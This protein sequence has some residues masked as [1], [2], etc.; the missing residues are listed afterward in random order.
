MT[1]EELIKELKRLPAHA[2]VRV[3][4]ESSIWEH[5]IINIDEEAGEVRI[6]YRESDE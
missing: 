5:P 1:V 2:Q 4:E 3:A 6:E